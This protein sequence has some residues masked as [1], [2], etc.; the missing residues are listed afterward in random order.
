MYE[1]SHTRMAKADYIRPVEALHGK[2]KKSDKVGFAKRKKSGTKFTVTRDDWTQKFS[3]AEKAQA[4][5]LRQ[6]KF[7]SV[8]MA[9]HERM[10]DPTQKT[11]DQLA[12]RNQSKYT[13]MF[14]FLFHLEWDAYEG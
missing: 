5:K 9:A 11:A 4:A 14:G 7:R 3:T 10:T 1:D 13:T 12:F 6:N 2:L 8:A